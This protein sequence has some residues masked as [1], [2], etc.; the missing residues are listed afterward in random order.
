MD[1]EN[2]VQQSK[3]N[4]RKPQFFNNSIGLTNDLPP[5]ELY[6]LTGG[7]DSLP[8]ESKDQLE[9]Y[10]S[11]HSDFLQNGPSQ[12]SSLLLRRIIQNPKIP[13]EFRSQTLFRLILDACQVLALNEVEISVWAIFLDKCVW[14]DNTAKLDYVLYYSALSAKS[15]TNSDVTPYLKYLSSKMS[16]FYNNYMQWTQ[17]NRNCLEVTD[18]ELNCIYKKLTAPQDESLVDYNFYVDDILQMAPPYMSDPRDSAI[19]RDFSRD[20]E[21]TTLAT[22]I[23]YPKNKKLTFS[24][25]SW[26]PNYDFETPSITPATSTSSIDSHQNSIL[27][28]MI[29]ERIDVICSEFLNCEVPKINVCPSSRSQNPLLSSLA[30]L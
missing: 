20:A 19:S 12:L 23:N 25:A 26:I 5:Y 6:E 21:D 2:S 11:L 13:C 30:N 28:P 7:D 3:S 17:R 10:E 18:R 8:K 4:E 24:D 16:N 27:S 15:Y 22:S 1:S 9:D 29:L 14:T